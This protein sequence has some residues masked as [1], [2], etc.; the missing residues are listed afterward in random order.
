MRSSRSGW[1]ARK[2]TPKGASVRCLTVRTASSELVGRHR[3]GGEDAEAP[4]RRRRRGQRGARHPAHARL[5]DRAGGSP[6]ARRTGWRGPGAA[7]PAASELP[8]LTVCQT[9]AQPT[10]GPP[11]PPTARRRRRLGRGRGRPEVR[12]S[13]PAGGRRPPDRT[14]CR[15]PPPRRSPRAP[16]DRGCPTDGLPQRGTAG[17][18]AAAGAATAATVPPRRCR[19][20]RRRRR[21]RPRRPAARRSPCRRWRPTT[22]RSQVA[23]PQPAASTATRSPSAVGT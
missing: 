4:G 18:G 2:L 20:T 11:R 22:G 10:A 8:N 17:V 7:G 23:A 21:R 1:S 9:W 14:R 12:V 5:H 15:R 13:P 3:D 16:G 6:P 19:R